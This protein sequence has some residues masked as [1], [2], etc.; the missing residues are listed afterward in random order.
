MALSVSGYDLDIL[1][2]DRDKHGLQTVYLVC[3]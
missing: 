3:Q 2:I 1:R